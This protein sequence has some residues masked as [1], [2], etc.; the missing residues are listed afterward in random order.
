MGNPKAEA[1]YSLCKD[2][3][4]GWEELFENFDSYA[5]LIR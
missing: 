3:T 5:D 4:S 1:A 2:N